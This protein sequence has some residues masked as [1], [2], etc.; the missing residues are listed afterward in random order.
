MLNTFRHRFLA[1]AVGLS[2]LATGCGMLGGGVSPDDLDGRDFVSVSRTTDGTDDALV[3]GSRVTLAFRG[4]DLSADAGCNS[5]GAGYEIRDGRLVVGEMRST[6]IAC[7][8]ELMAQDQWLQSFLSASPAVALDGVQLTLSGGD[9]VLTL[10]DRATAEPDPLLYDTQWQLDSLIDGSTV[11]AAPEGVDAGMVFGQDGGLSVRTGCNTGM[12]DYTIDGDQITFG[13][14]A[15]TRMAC[16]D[17][18]ASGVE[19]QLLTLLA[20]PTV[21]YDINGGVLTLRAGDG[22]MMF[23][24]GS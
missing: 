17:E 16:L 14:I 24:A 19:A 5:M 11:S 1:A 10:V 21:S 15:T 9:A 23:R 22:G 4:S 8:P 18:Q 3:A 13:P 6:A 12:G 20:A 2:L 7:D